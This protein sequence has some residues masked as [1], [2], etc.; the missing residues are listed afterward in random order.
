MLAVQAQ[1][2]LACYIIHRVGRAISIR[3]ALLAPCNPFVEAIT[4]VL[5]TGVLCTWV[6]VVTC[7]FPVRNI[8]IGITIIHCAQVLV[9]APRTLQVRTYLL[10]VRAYIVCDQ[11][12]VSGA[13]DA[14]VL[15]T[16]DP[17]VAI[18]VI[19]TYRALGQGAL[20]QV[21]TSGGR[22]TS[23]QRTG[24]SVVTGNILVATQAIHASIS[25][26]LVVVV[27]ILVRGTRF[28]LGF[29][30]IV[31][32]IHLPGIQR[33][34]RIRYIRYLVP[35]VACYILVPEYIRWT[36]VLRRHTLVP[37][38]H[39]HVPYIRW[40][41]N[42]RFMPTAATKQ[43]HHQQRYPCTCYYTIIVKHEKAS[44]ISNSPS[45]NSNK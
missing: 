24:Q 25:G 30:N 18:G 13:G 29:L 19:G 34:P 3:S 41:W 27:A 8:A 21:D 11:L 39:L 42:R 43:Q 9:V 16:P 14:L 44:W 33:I 32:D 28:D 31:Y 37:G 6:I 36:H 40:R 7:L 20:V 35:L 1:P 12:V 38:I 17:I 10:R 15:G 5:V 22:F 26:A 2:R 23:V 4:R 45:I